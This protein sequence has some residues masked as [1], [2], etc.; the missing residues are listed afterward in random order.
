MPEPGD[1]VSIALIGCGN[2]GGALLRAWLKTRI[3]ASFTIISPHSA[4]HDFGSDRRIKARYESLESVPGS[5]HKPDYCVVAV[6]PQNLEEIGPHLDKICSPSTCVISILAGTT[7]SRVISFLSNDQPAIRVMPNTPASI[8]AGITAMVAGAHCSA[9]HRELT[10]TLFQ[11]AGKIV[12][13]DDEELMNAATA[14]SGSG[15]AYFFAFVEALAE[16]GRDAGLP[17]ETAE[18][19]ARQT[20]TGAAALLDEEQGRGAAAL[21]R[22]VTS[23]GGTTEA[24]LAALLENDKGLFPLIRK[25]V[26][27]ARQRAE[28]LAE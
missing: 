4:S 5:A 18:K 16:A 15:P 21:R 20:C 12:W 24:A 13:L 28:H 10:E 23:K 9:A 22:A 1:S 27:A 19:L 8:G 2:M 14:V 26:H 11:A 7:I 17:A 3:D 6:K 25:T